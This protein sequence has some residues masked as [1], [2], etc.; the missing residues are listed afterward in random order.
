MAAQFR[1]FRKHTRVYRDD[2]HTECTHNR[3][4]WFGAVFLCQSKE[5]SFDAAIF[6]HFNFLEL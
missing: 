2:L 4:I 5:R 3:C 6:S 1:P